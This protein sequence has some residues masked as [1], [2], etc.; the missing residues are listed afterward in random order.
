MDYIR[1]YAMYAAIFGLFSFSWFGW[2]QER[3]RQSWRLYLGIGS[4]IGMLVCLLGVYLSITNW[5]AATAL[6]APE[7]FKHY[8]IFVYVEVILAGLGAFLLIRSKRSHYIAPWIAFVVGVHFIWL[9]DVF[10]DSALYVLAALL[11]VV[12]V[13]S[14]PL[15]RK[16]NVANSAITGIGAGISLLCFAIIGLIRFYLAS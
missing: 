11:I 12:S 7:A 15:S 3:P 1:D 6:D 14:L 2:A 16:L 13:L 9:R 4:G 8:L 5:S 10:Q